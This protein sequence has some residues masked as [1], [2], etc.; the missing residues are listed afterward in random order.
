M[1]QIFKKLFLLSFL[2]VGL[3]LIPGELQAQD[4]AKSLSA[5]ISW[6]MG[7]AQKQEIV[8]L[9]NTSVTAGKIYRLTFYGVFSNDITSN[10]G[11]EAEWVLSNGAQ[12][13]FA[14]LA[15]G[16]ESPTNLLAEIWTVNSN[17]GYQQIQT[18]NTYGT[19][20]TKHS[21]KIE[22][23]FTCTQSG[24]ID[25]YFGNRLKFPSTLY[26]G[27]AVVIEAF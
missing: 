9:S 22:C 25:L 12:G 27:S 23:V 21:M 4:V 16:Q 24:E 2:F 13:E 10:V 7:Q 17:S 19:N 3:S 18:D 11:L 6:G 20:G 1:N 8:D 26:E 5:D 14:G 15:I